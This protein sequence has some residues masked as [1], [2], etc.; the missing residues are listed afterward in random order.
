M[1]ESKRRVVFVVGSGRSGTSTDGG[2]AAGV[3]DARAAAGGAGRRDQPE[4]VRGVEVGGRP[5]PRAAAAVPRPGVRRPADGVVRDRQGQRVRHHPGPADRVAGAAVQGGGRRGAGHRRAGD[6]GPAAG[7]VP[8]P[9]EVGGAPHRRAAVVRHDAAPRHRGGRQQEALLRTRADRVRVQRGPAHRG[10]GEH[11]A[12]HRARDPR[13]RERLRPVRRPA[14][15]LDGPG[16]PARSGARP[17]GGQGRERQRHPQGAPVHR[18]RP[19]AGADDL[20]RR[21]GPGPAA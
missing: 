15:R 13:G 16:V 1:S 20:G 21:R 3:G 7:V 4:G 19:Q 12:A 18:P 17:R 11:D 2:R 10:L 8:G 5:P 9:L 6:Q 14:D